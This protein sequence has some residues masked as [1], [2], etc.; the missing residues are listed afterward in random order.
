MKRTARYFILLLL[1]VIV[2]TIGFMVVIQMW[3]GNE[4]VYFDKVVIDFIQARISPNLTKGMEWITFFGSFKWISIGSIVVIIWLMIYKRGKYSIFFIFTIVSGVMLNRVLKEIFQRERPDIHPLI[5]QGGY[6]FPSGHS[7]NS[8]VFYG[9]IAFLLFELLKHKFSRI[10]GI[11][12]AMLSVLLI[13]I[14]RIYLGV[15][16]PTDV[17][18]GYFIGAVWLFI[19]IFLYQDV[20]HLIKKKRQKSG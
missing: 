8:F 20:W 10:L 4:V 1:S 14:S 15:H 18:G 11:S 3:K 12:L 2:F 19:S 13:G 16:Y 6:S 9:L 5:H 17:I 7:M